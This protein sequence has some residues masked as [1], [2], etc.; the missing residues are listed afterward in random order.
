M[1]LYTLPKDPIPSRPAVKPPVASLNSWKEKWRMLG[2]WVSEAAE[3]DVVVE[4][5]GEEGVKCKL[6][7][8]GV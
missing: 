5:A 2:R 8:D 3:E 6:C 4:L 1:A 7:G